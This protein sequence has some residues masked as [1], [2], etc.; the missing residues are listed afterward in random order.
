[1]WVFVATEVGKERHEDCRGGKTAQKATRKGKRNG[2][3]GL[4]RRS[5]DGLN[6]LPAMTSKAEVVLGKAERFLG[7][8]P[9]WTGSS[10]SFLC[11]CQGQVMPGASSW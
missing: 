6:P 4:H 7:S 11:L 1:M 9:A 2:W 3:D 5:G 10:S 8:S